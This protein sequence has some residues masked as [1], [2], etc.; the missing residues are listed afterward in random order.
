MHS[1]K[2]SGARCASTANRRRWLYAIIIMT[3]S[4]SL[5]PCLFSRFLPNNL[6]IKTRNLSHTKTSFAIAIAIAIANSP[7][8]FARPN[9]QRLRTLQI[10]RLSANRLRRAQQPLVRRPPHLLRAIPR[11]RLPRSL[12]PTQQRRRLRARRL[13]QF[14]SSERTVAGAGAG[15]GALD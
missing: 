15:T 4:L 11:D 9:R 6:L 7:N 3:V 10:R 13:L 14:H 8:L 1:T 2:I 12:L 5:H